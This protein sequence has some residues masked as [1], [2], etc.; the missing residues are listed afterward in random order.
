VADLSLPAGVS[1]HEG[2]DA[3]WIT[4]AAGLESAHELPRFEVFGEEGRL[5]ALAS[6]LAPAL[7]GDEAL[8]AQL[9]LS[10]APVEDPSDRAA[11]H[12]L[13]VHAR[14]LSARDGLWRRLFGEGVRAYRWLQPHWRWDRWCYGVLVGPAPL[15]RVE[16]AVNALWEETCDRLVFLEPAGLAPDPAV[17]AFLRG[18]AEVLRAG[19]P[20]DDEDAPAARLETAVTLV[21]TGAHAQLAASAHRLVVAPSPIPGLLTEG[22]TALARA[23]GTVRL[24]PTRRHLLSPGALQDGDG[25]GQALVL[26][27]ESGTARWVRFG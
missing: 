14:E 16:A 8:V 3:L 10:R 17:R 26:E 27:P 19:A 22:Q 9:E 15:D 5:K 24:E 2:E 20:A 1:S 12:L 21:D 7:L 23:G 25:G 13:R 4:P 11:R 6:T 18:K